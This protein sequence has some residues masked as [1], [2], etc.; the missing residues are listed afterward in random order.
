[1]KIDPSL[2]DVTLTLNQVP[3]SKLTTRTN[4]NTLPTTS[5]AKSCK[6]WTGK[7]AYLPTH[8]PPGV[9]CS[10]FLQQLH[11]CIP[12]LVHHEHAYI[13]MHDPFRQLPPNICLCWRDGPTSS[14]RSFVGAPCPIMTTSILGD[15]LWSQKLSNNFLSDTFGQQLPRCWHWF[16]QLRLNASPLRFTKLSCT[17]PRLLE[18]IK[19][20]RSHFIQTSSSP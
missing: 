17:S 19:R 2:I 6:T 1:M 10:Y 15:N 9:Q 13:R 5:W 3:R 12:L 4:L 20:L 11:E 18:L 14:T 8:P 7:K 16:W